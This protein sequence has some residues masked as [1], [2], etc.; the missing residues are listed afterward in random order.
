MNTSED[1]E[2]R[3][4][5]LYDEFLELNDIYGSADELLVDAS[6]KLDPMQRQFLS[7]FVLMWESINQ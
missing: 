6:I 7:A 5:G 2:W 4:Q 3:L 1:L